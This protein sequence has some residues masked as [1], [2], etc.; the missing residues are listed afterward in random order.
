MVGKEKTSVVL[1]TDP[2]GRNWEEKLGCSKS[3]HPED[4]RP[5]SGVALPEEGL[6]RGLGPTVN[7]ALGEQDLEVEFAALLDLSSRVDLPSQSA[8]AA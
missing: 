6:E 4:L 1:P 7:R 5:P 3:Q 2:P 8:A